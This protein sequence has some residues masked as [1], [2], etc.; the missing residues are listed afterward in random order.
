MLMSNSMI[1][2]LLAKLRQQGSLVVTLRGHC[3]EP[4]L[5]GGDKALVKPVDTAELGDICLAL[6]PSGAVGLH[7]V[8]RIASKTLLL[9]GDYEGKY[10]EIF[11]GDILAKAC[12]FCF[13]GTDAWVDYGLSVEKRLEITD[14]SL[15]VVP[16]FN[17]NEGDRYQKREA[18]W[19]LNKALREE[20]IADAARRHRL[21]GQEPCQL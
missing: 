18:I 12:A 1:T 16:E 21:E 19:K 10:E 6:S 13:D 5:R 3:M 9:K 14:L 8:V 4:F 20:I 15:G 17:E 7:R 2:V 11:K